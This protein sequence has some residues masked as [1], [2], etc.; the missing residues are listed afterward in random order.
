MST[1][2][3]HVSSSIIANFIIGDDIHMS[4]KFKIAPGI[5]GFELKPEFVL[6]NNQTGLFDIDIEFELIDSNQ[7]NSHFIARVGMEIFNRFIDLLA[8]TI[9]EPV[10]VL[11]TPKI[12]K[13]IDVSR[14]KIIILGDVVLERKPSILT[15]FPYLNVE[16]TEKMFVSLRWYHRA[17]TE[18]DIVDKFS[19]LMVAT[20]V[21]AQSIRDDICEPEPKS[22]SN[23]GHVYDNK[24]SLG[25]TVRSFLKKY[26][27]ISED[28]SKKIWNDRTKLKH[29]GISELFPSP[30]EFE[31]YY[32]LCM[33]AYLKG[34]RSCIEVST[35]DLL[36]IIELKKIESSP[37]LNVVAEMNPEEEKKKENLYRIINGINLSGKMLT[38]IEYN[39][40]C[41][42]IDVQGSQDTMRIKFRSCEQFAF[43][44]I[45]DVANKKYIMH[46]MRE[47]RESKLARRI[48]SRDVKEGLGK[49][50]NI[51]IF[52]I[53]AK[54]IWMIMEIRCN[55]VEVSRNKY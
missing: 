16:I 40:N 9:Q 5:K 24:P 54:R 45:S 11:G 39:N 43:N 14:E 36:P 48:I 47:F 42:I 2:N 53:A 7:N 29:G 1:A 26:G 6:G 21:F 23:C 8:L 15:K 49:R 51:G 18:H 20:E 41:L 4:P 13:K 32:W 10:I 38:N 44:N 19:S 33:E 30:K 46:H 55:D 17:L 12:F 35:S 25:S 34:I 50:L 52:A 3:W 28:L 31:G 27:R 37:L 22:C